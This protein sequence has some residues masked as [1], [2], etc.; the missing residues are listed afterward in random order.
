MIAWLVETLVASTLLMLV[1]LAIRTPVARR[2]G[3][4]VAYA[5]WLLPA[6]RMI[7]PPLPAEVAP[8][9]MAAIPQAIHMDAL[10]AA[11]LAGVSAPAAPIERAVDWPAL[12]LALWVA[13]AGAFFVWHLLSYRRFVRRTLADA[14]QLP[15]F[16]RDGI[17][18]C[19]SPHAG[20]PFAAGIFLKSIV[21]PQDWRKRYAPDELR[22]ALEHERQHHRRCDMSANLVALGVL[23]VHWWNPIAHRAHR[24]FR[25]DQEL[26]CDALVLAEATPAERQAYGSALLKSACDRLPVAACALGAGEDLKRRLRMMASYRPDRR[27]GRAG[28]LITAGLVGGGLL[29]TASGGIA[30][31]TGRKVEEQVRTI[32]LEQSEPREKAAAAPDTEARAEKKKV[33]RRRTIVRLK[34]GEKNIFVSSGEGPAVIHLGKHRDKDH[35]AL[36]VPP[37]DGEKISREIRAELER[38]LP[39][40]RADVERARAEARAAGKPCQG[41]MRWRVVKPGGEAQESEKAFKCLEL[42]EAN[43]PEMRKRM[44]E[45]LQQAR[46]NMAESLNEEWLAQHRARVL[47]GLDRQI[48]RLQAQDK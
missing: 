39:R 45:S 12:L 40:I 28:A 48:E 13:G 29:L 20:G 21:L 34:D 15:R 17:E 1:V 30:A 24:A 19:A 5:L 27:R 23:A 33:E 18:V 14:T 2:F 37:V 10:L 47:E 8:A 38:E 31:E 16:D 42:A 3:P 43:S 9:P 7:L 44:L 25:V 41:T 22:L 6:L 32:I 11:A 36:F 46:K 26:A 35:A 4:R